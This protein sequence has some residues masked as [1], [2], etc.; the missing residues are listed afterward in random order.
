[1]IIIIVL[2]IMHP[3]ECKAQELDSAAIRTDISVVQGMTAARS[4]QKATLYSA[5]LPGLGQAYNNK[6]WKIP[7]IYG[8]G[9]A[10]VCYTLH[11]HTQYK[12]FRD[13][14]LD[15]FSQADPKPVLIDGRLYDYDI[16]PRG[17]DG[18]RR[19][20]DLCILGT[21]AVYF[22]NIVDAMI[23]AHFFYYDVSDD[24]S[25]RIAPVF[26]DDPVATTTF[27]LNF[28]LGF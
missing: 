12:K 18:F 9:G 27:G 21:A 16:L 25:L 26:M 8:A 24:L 10:F 3:P 28:H 6:Y 23:D 5:I 20:R 17:R 14:F 2:C 1:M 13:A 11:W 7:I 4:P 22:L 19:Y 15:G